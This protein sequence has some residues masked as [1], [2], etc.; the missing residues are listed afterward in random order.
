MTMGRWSEIEL[1][2]IIVMPA[3]LYY[4]MEPITED[5]LK[6]TA[7]LWNKVGEITAGYGVKLTCHHEFFCG[8]QSEADIDTFY[9]YTDPQYVSLFVDTA[10][11][12]IAGVDPV[13]LYDRHAHRVSGFHFKDT[14]NVATG[15]DHRHRPDSEIMAPTTGKWFYEMGTPE[16][17]VDFEAMMTRRPGRTVTGLD[18]RRARQGQQVGRRLLREHRDLP[19]VRR[20]RPRAD[21][22]MRRVMNTS[23]GRTRSTSGSPSS[24]TSSAASTTSARSRRSRSPASTAS[25]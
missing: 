12:C 9:S 24:T 18:L 2:N 23:D 3:T 17:L 1:D 16:G 4:D 15:D 19:L 25:S 10:Q 5:K 11:H 21:L 22:P 7:E 20:E 6:I 8:I 13:A 14:R